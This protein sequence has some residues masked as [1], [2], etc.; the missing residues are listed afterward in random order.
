[1]NN[2]VD[3]HQPWGE[4]RRLILAEIERINKGMVELNNKM[5]ANSESR[6]SETSQIQVEIA[7]LKVKSG[8]FG[9][10]T[11]GFSAATILFLEFLFKH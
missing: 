5:D 11:G 1:M 8:I 6:F 4:Y 2:H 10:M 7:M 3:D 9:A